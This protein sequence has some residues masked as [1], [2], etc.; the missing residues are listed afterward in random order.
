MYLMLGLAA[1]AAKRFQKSSRAAVSTVPAK[2]IIILTGKKR[3][4]WADMLASKRHWVEIYISYRLHHI[5][6]Y[7]VGELLQ[8]EGNRYGY[9]SLPDKEAQ[10]L[11]EVLGRHGVLVSCEFPPNKSSLKE[12]RKAASTV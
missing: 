9:I 2:K 7:P 6:P 12:A 11:A 8:Q 10:A 3:K 4:E 5:V 1:L